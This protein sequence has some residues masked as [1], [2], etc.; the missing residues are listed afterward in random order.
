MTG[1]QVI[2]TFN[3]PLISNQSYLVYTI[4]GEFRRGLRGFHGY[5]ICETF[6]IQHSMIKLNS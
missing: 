3:S 4:K 5:I 2:I 1:N 6:A